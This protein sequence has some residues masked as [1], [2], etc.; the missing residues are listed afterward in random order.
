MVKDGD[1]NKSA[2]DVNEAFGAKLKYVQRNLVCRR[3]PSTKKVTNE[4]K[5]QCKNGKY[6]VGELWVTTFT[7]VGARSPHPHPLRIVSMLHHVKHATPHDA[8]T[9]PPLSGCTNGGYFLILIFPP[10]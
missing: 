3:K 7:C 4:R 2:C 9:H 10:L 1:P 8:P 6:P 5:K